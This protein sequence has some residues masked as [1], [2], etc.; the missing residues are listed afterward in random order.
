M[1]SLDSLNML[2]TG[3]LAS[4]SDMFTAKAENETAALSSEEARSERLEGESK[5]ESFFNGKVVT[6]LTNT[7]E[8]IQKYSKYAGPALGVVKMI[9]TLLDGDEE[10]FSEGSVAPGTVVSQETVTS[11]KQEAE[12]NLKTA[13]PDSTGP[14]ALEK[15]AAKAKIS[16]MQMQLANTLE[17]LAQVNEVIAKRASGE[18]PNPVLNVAAMD[19]ALN[20]I[21]QTMEDSGQ[22]TEEQISSFR[23]AA[24]AGN[25]AAMDSYEKFVVNNLATPYSE[26]RAALD[27]L[28]ARALGL[29]VDTDEEAPIFDTVFGPPKSTTGKFILSEDGIYYDSRSGSIPYITA[30]KIDSKSW[31]LRYASNRGG[32]GIE[33]SQEQTGRFADTIFSEDFDDETGQVLLFYKYDDILQGMVNDRELQTADVS[34]KISDLIA[35]GYASDSAVVKNYQESYASIGYAYDL[36]IKKRKKQLQIAALFGPFGVTTSADIR[37]EGLFYQTYTKTAPSFK[38]SLC[39]S[40]IPLQTIS[41]SASPDSSGIEFIPRIPLNNF[42]Y[43]KDVGLIPE[44]STQKEA[45]LHSSDLDDTTNPVIPVFLEQGPGAEFELIPELAISPY[46]TADWVNT[47][48]DTDASTVTSSTVEGIVPYLRTLDDS[49]VTDSLVACYNFLEPEA[50]TTPDSDMFGVRNYVDNGY[51]TNAKLVGDASSIFIS[52][53]SIPYLQGTLYN[54]SGKYGVRYSYLPKGSYVRL[55]NNYRA[56]RPYPASQKIDDLMYNAKGWSMDFWVYAPDLYTGMTDDHRYKLVAANEN[57]GDPVNSRVTTSI[58]TTASLDGAIRN[59]RKTRTKGMLIG[60]RDKGS[61]GTSL[62]AGLE[63]VV[64]PTVAQNNAIWGKSVCIAES[65][66]GEGG[67]SGCRTELGFKVPASSTTDSGYSIADASAGFTHI[68]IACDTKTD[69]ISLFVNGEFLASS[70]ISTAFDIEPGSP[71][72][73]PSRISEGHFHETRGAFGEKLYD[74]SLPNIPIFTPWILGGGFTDGIAESPFT[75][76]SSLNTTFPGFLGTNTNTSYYAVA[77]DTGGGPIGQHT[78]TTPGNEIAGLGGYTKSG[79]NYQIARSGLDGHLGSFKMYSKPLSTKEVVTNY[80]AQSP[81]FNGIARPNHL[82]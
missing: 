23:Q 3:A 51:T 14:L 37:G 33:Y 66:S 9:K 41:F 61:P 17:T 50:A 64:L 82:L 70:L 27:I 44:L 34:A 79:S 71:I 75:L 21:I 18:L 74:G 43:L 63:F 56:N 67:G 28:K 58:Y 78:D 39:G 2:P 35:E 77:S 38:E 16:E 52:G 32:R 11:L 80:K 30:R 36:K 25:S 7:I 10:P 57:C 6:K 45:M 72:N 65:V 69:A 26:N 12:S 53:V 20:K 73:I 49:I 5:S 54:P 60:W 68:A 1:F 62:S 22:Y 4:I 42:S 47:S 40:E 29:E 55:P 46:G 19:S 8:G 81:F 13:P 76:Q 59:N 31:E 15:A 24:E 48:G